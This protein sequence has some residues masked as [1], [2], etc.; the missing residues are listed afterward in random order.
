MIAV[1]EDPPPEVIDRFYFYFVDLFT[2]FYIM[3]MKNPNIK[4]STTT[5]TKNINRLENILEIVQESDNPDAV[6]VVGEAIVQT[7]NNIIKEGEGE[8]GGEVEEEVV[9]LLEELEVALVC[10]LECGEE[11]SVILVFFSSSLDY[12]CSIVLIF[13]S[14]V[15]KLELV[16]LRVC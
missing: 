10:S 13:L 12:Y 16:L 5:K 1:V 15:T 2:F 7:V 4:L 11:P 8:G 3:V 9:E 6:E 14:R